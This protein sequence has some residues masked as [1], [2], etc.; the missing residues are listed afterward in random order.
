[1]SSSF[2]VFFLKIVLAILSS[3]DDH[4][5]LRMSLSIS[6]TKASWDLLGLH[7]SVDQLGNIAI[8]K[9]LSF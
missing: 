3:L 6:E 4:M 1:M 5:N 7:E 8:L 9:L 2:I